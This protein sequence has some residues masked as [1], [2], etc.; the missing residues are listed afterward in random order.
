M[1]ER[2]AGTILRRETGH[3]ILD[4]HGVGYGVDVTASVERGLGSEGEPAAVWVY[5]HVNEGAITLFGFSSYGERRAFEILISVSGLGPRAAISILSTFDPPQL[6]NLIM[7]KNSK[8][9]TQ[10][11][12]IGLKRAEK[13]LLELKDKIKELAAGLKVESGGVGAPGGVGVEVPVA[14]EPGLPLTPNVQNA[15][16]A[17]MALQVPQAMAARAIA[18]AIE[19]AGE[20]AETETLVREGLKH[21]R[22]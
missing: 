19:T 11:P 22:G 12:G 15:V 2:L 14:I 7:T 5:T 13:L 16:A 18:R 3:V 21:R 1:I 17:L 9:L 6:V 10:A 8:A 20:S 4:A